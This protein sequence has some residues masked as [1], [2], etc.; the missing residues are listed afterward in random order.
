MTAQLFNDDCLDV[1]ESLDLS[2]VDAV[3]TDPPY[4]VN[5]V[6]KFYSNVCDGGDYPPIHGDNK[7]FDPSPWLDFKRVVLFGANYYADKLPPSGCWLI[8]DKRCGVAEVNQA[9]AEL[10]W[11]K[12]APGTVPRVFRH[13]WMGMLKDS[14]RTDR[15]CHPTQK[16]VALMKW[17]MEKAGVPEGGT[18][19]DP[20]MGSG[21]TGVACMET[22]RPFIGIEI[23]PPYFEIAEERIKI[24]RQQLNLFTEIA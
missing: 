18:V 8:W 10:A 3:I 12:G 11:T 17:V 5:L 19:L 24:A 23:E 2:A 16:P 9:D 13:L 14:E 20:Y 1:I 21:S 6:T 4:G 15:R 22:G 7:P